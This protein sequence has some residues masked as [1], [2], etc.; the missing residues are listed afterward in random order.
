ML[1]AVDFHFQVDLARAH[2]GRLNAEDEGVVVLLLLDD[3]FAQPGEGFAQMVYRLLNGL[4]IHLNQ[5]DVFRVAGLRLQIEFVQRRAATEGKML[6]QEGTAVYRHQR[7]AD[8]Q[9][10]L[11]QT[12][13]RP[14]Y[15]RTPLG[16]EC[17]L[18]H[19]S[20]IS[21]SWFT[22]TFHFL[23][24][25]AS[26]TDAPSLSGTAFIFIPPDFIRAS[27]PSAMSSSSSTQSSR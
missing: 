22:T 14:R 2:I 4:G 20:S 25:S 11:H 5:V 7:P 9:I 1:L 17:S 24:T 15:N 12:R 21:I 26:S 6:L 23:S 3:G 8:N 19:K 18:Y 16:Y 10:L 13:R 27:R